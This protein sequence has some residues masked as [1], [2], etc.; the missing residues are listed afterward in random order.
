MLIIAHKGLEVYRLSLKLTQEIY[1]ITN[2]F[3]KEE[4]F[5]W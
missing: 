1:G 2:L 4:R 5:G 3:P